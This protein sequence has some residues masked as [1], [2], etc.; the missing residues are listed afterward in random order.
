MK[1]AKTGPNPY[2]NRLLG[3]SIRMGVEK[4]LL[5]L[6]QRNLTDL[7]MQ[8]NLKLGC[9]H[10][11]LS[12]YSMLPL[13]YIAGIFMNLGFLQIF[14]DFLGEEIHPDPISASKN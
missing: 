12:Q 9:N 13:V 6:V 4:D 7:T 3:D 5:D 2:R 10:Y 8:S 11:F 14:K 1:L